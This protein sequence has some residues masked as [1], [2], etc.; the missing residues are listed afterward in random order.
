MKISKKLTAKDRVLAALSLAKLHQRML[1]TA[2]RKKE[3]PNGEAAL[4]AR[5]LANDLRKHHHRMDVEF[6]LDMIAVREHRMEQDEL[7]CFAEAQI[8]LGVK[9][10]SPQAAEARAI[11]NNFGIGDFHE[12]I[13]ILNEF[14]LR[15][16]FRQTVKTG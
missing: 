13:R 11:E 1:Q 7:C 4:C 8:Y 5:A 10:I 3:F 16:G 6:L 14:D 2:M 15:R 12:Y 9:E